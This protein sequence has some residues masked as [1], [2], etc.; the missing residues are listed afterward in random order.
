MSNWI[1]TKDRLP[2]TDGEYLTASNISN[3]LIMYS[4]MPFAKVGKKMAF[5]EYDENLNRHTV[6]VDAWMPIEPYKGVEDRKS[7]GEESA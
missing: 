6:E 4:V 3:G 7:D 5:H 2:G 1:S